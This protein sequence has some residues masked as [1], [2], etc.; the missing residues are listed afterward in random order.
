MALALFVAGPAVDPDQ[1]AQAND[2]YVVGQE[3][4]KPLFNEGCT[5]PEYT[6]C[7]CGVIV[8]GRTCPANPTCQPEQP[9]APVTVPTEP[10]T[11]P[12]ERVSGAKV[13][14]WRCCADGDGREGPAGRAVLVPKGGSRHSVAPTGRSL[15][16]AR[17]IDRCRADRLP[18]LPSHRP[19]DVAA[20][21]AYQPASGHL[22]LT[23]GNRPGRVAHG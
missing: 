2:C 11:E 4:G 21:E 15:D 10:I 8:S 1:Q 17:Q 5:G 18:R 20:A 23:Q 9:T 19:I 16:P 6:V 22:A 12:D 3:D 7:P 13:P 14:Q